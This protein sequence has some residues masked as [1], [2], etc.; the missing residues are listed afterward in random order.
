[1]P[2]PRE[3]HLQ[4]KIDGNIHSR[5]IRS[6]NK[7]VY[8]NAVTGIKGTAGSYSSTPDEVK[9]P[10]LQLSWRRELLTMKIF[11]CFFLS[12]N[13]SYQFN[14]RRVSTYFA[15][16]KTWNNRKMIAETGCYIFRQRSL[17]YR[18]HHCLN[19]LTQIIS[20]RGKNENNYNCDMYEHG[21]RTCKA[22]KNFVII[23]K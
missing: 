23:V 3:S 4:S 12:L 19:S 22:G 8:E 16:G 5:E 17:C 11:N 14:F 13:R 18:S 21:K 2:L 6:K 10:A 20:R 7:S 9:S 1:M 15:N